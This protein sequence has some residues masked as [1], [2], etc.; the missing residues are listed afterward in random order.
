MCE[1]NDQPQ[2]LEPVD[3]YVD[4]I[5]TLKPSWYDDVIVAGI[6]GKNDPFEIKMNERNLPILAPSCMY[7]GNQTAV[8]ALRTSDFLSQ[9]QFTTQKEICTADLTPA[10]VEIAALLK[11]S[12]GERCFQ[13]EVLDLDP[14]TEGL[15]ADCTVS[16][17]RQLPDGT[18]KEIDLIPNCS[19]NVIPCW[20]IEVDPTECHYTKTHQKLVVERGGV[21]PAADIEVRASCVT[22]AGDGMVM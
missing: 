6:V 5:K 12:I 2:Y 15:Q 17:Y 22:T 7:D 11:R 13:S 20:R 18:E 14:T 16:D 21:I 8:P 10:M 9:F 3:R 1:P 4:Y 19:F